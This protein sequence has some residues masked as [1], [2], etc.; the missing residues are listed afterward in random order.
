MTQDPTRRIPVGISSCLLGQPVRYD[1]SHKRDDYLI[2]VLGEYFEYLPFCPEVA[3]GMGTPR[4]PIRLAGNPSR[5][6]AVGVEA[7][8]L[9]V[10][11]QLIDYAHSVTTNGPRISGYIFKCGSPSCGMQD[12]KV[13]D[14]NGVPDGTSSGLYAGVVMHSLPLLPVEEESRLRDSAV[15][16]SFVERVIHYDSWWRATRG[17]A[18][19]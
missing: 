17:S 9:D 2:E 6:R 8:D 10:T 15:R 13:Y 18:I 12:V 14:S 5:P 11:E 19:S 16:D 3:I 7:R 4:P 1:G